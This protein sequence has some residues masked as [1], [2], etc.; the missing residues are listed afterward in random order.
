MNNIFLIILIII[1]FFFISNEK[2]IDDFINRKYMSYLLLLLI[3]YFVYQNYNLAILVIGLLIFVFMNVD[4]KDKVNYEKF[5]NY[6]ELFKEYFN[7]K[8]ELFTNQTSDS[9]VQF[10]I[11]PYKDAISNILGEHNDNS[12]E[13]K[14]EEKKQQTEP[15]KNDV[16]Q[17]KEMYDNIKLELKKLGE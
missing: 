8:K 1:L 2:K 4:F 3:I 7:S 13:Q 9:N 5:M 15:F 17:L 11:K 16:A 12:D 6:Y 14:Q 10:D